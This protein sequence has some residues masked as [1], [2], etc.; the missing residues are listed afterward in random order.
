MLRFVSVFNLALQLA[1]GEWITHGGQLIPQVFFL[2]HLCTILPLWGCVL[3]LDLVSCSGIM[4]CLLKC[5][6]LGGL[7][8]NIGLKFQFS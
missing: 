8:G 3:D 2:Y 1:W 6:S 4:V 5:N 7:C